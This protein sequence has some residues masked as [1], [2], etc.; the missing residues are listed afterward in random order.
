MGLQNKIDAVARPIENPQFVYAIAH[1]LV[2]AQVTEPHPSQ[3]S[4]NARPS[5]AIL[6]AFQPLSKGAAASS[7]EI[8][9]EFIWD[10]GFS[11]G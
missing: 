5:P 10:D 1:A 7:G 3:A 11:H 4:I 8:L 2:V 9:S 6:E